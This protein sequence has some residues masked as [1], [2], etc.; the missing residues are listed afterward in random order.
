MNVLY[1][2]LK[3][4]YFEQIQEGIKTVEYR[5]MSD[6]WAKRLIDFK[7]GEFRKFDKIIFR[8]GYGRNVPTIEADF[9][10]I[11]I[12]YGDPDFFAIG[13]LCYAIKFRCE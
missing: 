11:G 8:N 5:S 4:K 13:E 10:D 12:E 3:R 7:K 9:V 1:L 6:Y 2:T